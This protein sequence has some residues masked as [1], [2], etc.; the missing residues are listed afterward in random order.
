[1]SDGGSDVEIVTGVTLDSTSPS[2]HAILSWSVAP[3]EPRVM[4]AANDPSF[5]VSSKVCSTS[6]SAS[7]K[8]MTTLPQSVESPWYVQRSAHATLATQYPR[9]PT[10]SQKIDDAVGAIDG[11]GDDGKDEGAGAGTS[12]GAPD[13]ADKGARDTEGAD[14]TARAVKI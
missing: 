12:D 4:T 8:V 5:A 2:A 3:S 11:A 13:G 7:S 9:A 14:V 1:M 6:P 10:V